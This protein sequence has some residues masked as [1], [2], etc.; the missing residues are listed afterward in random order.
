MVNASMAQNGLPLVFASD[1]LRADK[2][3]ALAAMT[4]FEMA[5]R[6]IQKTFGPTRKWCFCRGRAWDD[7][8][9]GLG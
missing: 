4:E 8:Y 7:A 6:F 9:M 2:D 5:L 1:D 3:V